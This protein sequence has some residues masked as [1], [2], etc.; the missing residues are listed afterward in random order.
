[1]EKAFIPQP[2]FL[3]AVLIVA[4]LCIGHTHSQQVQL[5][6]NS[7]YNWGVVIQPLFDDDHYMVC[8]YAD[9]SATISFTTSILKVN[10][11]RTDFSFVYSKNIRASVYCIRD[12][13]TLDILYTPVEVWKFTKVGATYSETSKPL[14]GGLHTSPGYMAYMDCLKGSSFC[15]SHSSDPANTHY[16]RIDRSLDDALLVPILNTRNTAGLNIKM[17]FLFENSS[18]VY[19]FIANQD[20]V[21]D[22]SVTDRNGLIVHKTHASPVITIT[23]KPKNVTYTVGYITGNLIKVDLI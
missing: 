4:L 2:K 14:T 7:V 17:T 13:D 19:H 6:A 1:M 21:V 8:S 10:P 11:T 18:F 15:Y 3:T 9:F 22:L 12:T 16:Y 20:M 23:G 5:R